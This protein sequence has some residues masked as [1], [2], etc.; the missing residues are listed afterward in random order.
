MKSQ[1]PKSLKKIGTPR[2][3]LYNISSRTPINL[4]LSSPTKVKRVSFRTPKSGGSK[5]LS[6]FMPKLKL[7][8]FIV[9]KGI[10]QIDPDMYK[11]VIPS[12]GLKNVYVEE[13]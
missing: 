12:S 11:L 5:S 1:T 3:P 2:T 7:S 13:I 4:K 8:K 9:K 6:F 10:C